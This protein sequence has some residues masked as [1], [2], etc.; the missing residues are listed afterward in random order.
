MQK[1]RTSIESNPILE[2]TKSRDEAFMR[3]I[4]LPK[5]CL[6]M[7]YVNSSYQNFSFIKAVIMRLT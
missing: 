3:P 6:I 4:Y 7:R 2:L 5:S 1:S